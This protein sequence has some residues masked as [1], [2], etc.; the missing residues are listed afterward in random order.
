MP[1]GRLARAAGPLERKISMKF[2]FPNF[3]I[4]VLT[5]IEC[6]A[7]EWACGTS[8]RRSGRSAGRTRTR[9]PERPRVSGRSQMALLQLVPF[10]SALKAG[11]T[12]FPRVAVRPKSR[13]KKPPAG[14]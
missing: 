14:Q 8:S 11:A 13:P 5:F 2:V 3:E 12:S 10:E 6:P 9:G 1:D 4:D 7:G